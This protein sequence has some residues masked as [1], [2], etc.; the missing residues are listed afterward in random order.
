MTYDFLVVQAR[1]EDINLPSVWIR[2]SQEC[3]EFKKSPIKIEYKGKNCYVQCRTVDQTL[4]SHTSY[5]NIVYLY[6]NEN[7]I[8]ISEHYREILGI[9]EEVIKSFDFYGPYEEKN[10]MEKDVHWI[11][12]FLKHTVVGIIGIHLWQRGNIQTYMLKFQF[13]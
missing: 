13:A 7:I 2:I 10:S 1:K 6:K 5:Q 3:N 8:F 11:L 12:L 4:I 9:K